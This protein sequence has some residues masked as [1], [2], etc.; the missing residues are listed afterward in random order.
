MPCGA[1]KQKTIARTH[2]LILEFKPRHDLSRPRRPV[3]RADVDITEAGCSLA[4]GVARLRRGCIGRRRIVH[5]GAIE[6]VG[7]LRANLQTHP[8]PDAEYAGETEILRRPPLITVIAV[9][10]SS[11]AVLSSGRV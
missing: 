7:E 10:G 8:F 4:R 1:S 5:L 2:R 9:I 11:R 3:R 6:D